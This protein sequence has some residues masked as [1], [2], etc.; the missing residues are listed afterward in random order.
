MKRFGWQRVVAS[1]MLLAAS[2]VAGA[3]T[4]PQYGGALQVTMR[5][6]P[7]SLDPALGPSPGLGNATQVDSLA[8]RNLLALIFETLVTVD[9]R[10]RI[11]AGLA[12]EWQAAP[13][14]Q[15]WRFRLRRGVKF[16]DETALTAEIAASSLRTANP[17]WKVFAEGDSVIVER[18][19][20]DVELPAELAL[21]RNSI[22]KRNGG[23]KLSGTGPFHIEDWQAGKKLTLGAEENHWRGRAFVDRIEVEMGRNVHEQL[24][25]L[26]LGKAGLVE[27]APEQGHRVAME[28]RRVS[29]SQPMELVALVFGGDAQTADEKL[30]RS[31]LAHSVER[32]SMRSALLQGAGQAAAS[33]LPNWMSG[34]A[35]AFATDA[36]LKQARHE[37][38]Q[39]GT[40]ANWTVRYDA[41]DSVARLLVERVALNAR[42]AGI[43]L[44]PTAAATADILRSDLLRSEL[45][46]SELRL[47]RIPLASADPWI[48]LAN[49]AGT[50][51]MAMP[52][53]NGDRVEDLYSAEQALLAGQRVIPLFHLPAEWASSP[54]VKGWRPG[55]DGGWRLDEVWVGKERQ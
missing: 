45:P 42:D 10:G 2:T 26:E 38:E 23:G 16:H 28:G 22:V 5:E 21:P 3:T 34:Y 44:Q 36:D 11:H 48:A 37:R 46:R 1:S 49:V 30:L 20:G 40:A 14:N 51:G 9:D 13:G 19:R 15:R 4:R 18:D 55:A 41:N 24:V 29:S 8:R 25:A 50:L 6:A 52:K 39:V 32:G 17:S 31:A 7:E 54:A 35:M 27:V 33:I 12:V 47:V 53:V 43:G